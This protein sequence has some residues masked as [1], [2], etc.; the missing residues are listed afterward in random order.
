MQELSTTAILDARGPK[1]DVDLSRPYAFMNEVERQ[2][3]G[4][5]QDVST[6]FLTNR[7]CPFHCLMCDLWKNTTDEATPVGAIPSQIEF[8]LS[9]LP[10]APVIKLYNSGNFFDRQAIPIADHPRII[11]LVAPYRHVIVE[12]HPRLCTSE[13]ARFQSRLNGSFEVA[14]GLETIHPTVL[15]RLN[16]QMTVDD[17]QRAVDLLVASEIVV[18]AFILLKP[19]FVGEQEAV[20]W[21]LRSIEWSFSIGVDCCAVIPTRGGNGIMDGLKRDG[22]FSPPRLESLEAVMAEAL[23]FGGNRVFV[24]LWDIEKLFVCSHCGPDRRDR[25]HHANLHQHLPP[26][27]AC[28]HCR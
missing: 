10:P 22:L 8:A 20:D 23:G 14:L 19:P 9:L 4:T 2:F 3:D 12:N 16:K 24:D 27:I 28:S 1:N 5:L 11:D 26:P 21:A 25:L 13:V 15:P 7:E 17:F 18:R 6:L